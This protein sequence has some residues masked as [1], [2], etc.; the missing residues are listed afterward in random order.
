[1]KA[2]VAVTDGKPINKLGSPLHGK[3]TMY[4]TAR[5]ITVFYF[6]TEEIP[7]YAIGSE[8]A[9]PGMVGVNERG[10]VL[11]LV[12]RD[13]EVEKLTDLQDSFARS[14][15]HSTIAEEGMS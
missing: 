5:G 10:T 8:H 3:T 13:G 7:D 9:A 4:V 12:L 14:I 15:M 2:H 6:N 11:Y 1:M